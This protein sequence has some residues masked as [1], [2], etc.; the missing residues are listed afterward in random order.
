MPELSLIP[1]DVRQKKSPWLFSID[2]KS[3]RLCS[4]DGQPIAFFLHEMADGR[5]ILP[6]FWESIE[7]LGVVADDGSQIW[8]FPEKESLAKIKAYLNWTL[9]IQ[10]EEPITQLRKEAKTSFCWAI[11]CVILG[12]LVEG[13][14]A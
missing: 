1:V 2:E 13:L 12:L 3:A 14:Q 6:S 11:A 4:G 8:F 9:A 5:I 10:G 7:H